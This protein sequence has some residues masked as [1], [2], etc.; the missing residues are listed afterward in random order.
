MRATFLTIG[1][2]GLAVLVAAIP[3]ADAS[4][5]SD[6]RPPPPDSLVQPC[7]PCPGPWGVYT[8]GTWHDSG[9]ECY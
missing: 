6:C 2:L 9:F 5:P 7:R 4:A 1:L 8:L 3:P